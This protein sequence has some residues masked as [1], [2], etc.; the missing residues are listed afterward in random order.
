[1]MTVK[2]RCFLPTDLVTSGKDVEARDLS[3][4]KSRHHAT[5]REGNYH[6]DMNHLVNS[7]RSNFSQTW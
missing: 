2:W 7:G 4:D 6:E 1:M 3:W 5:A